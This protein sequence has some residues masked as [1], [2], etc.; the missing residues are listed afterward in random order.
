MLWPHGRSRIARVLIIF[1][2]LASFRGLIPGLCGTLAAFD[3]AESA[4]AAA[5]CCT[6][7]HCPPP[8]DGEARFAPVAPAHAPCA[9]CHLVS[10][11]A[12]VQPAPMVETPHVPAESRLW[13]VTQARPH[14]IFAPGRPCRAPPL[15]FVAAA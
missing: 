8:G 4:R 10:A 13:S 15:R 3:D 6:M 14:D 5:S 1:Y 7:T 2:A 9:F 12:P 11:L